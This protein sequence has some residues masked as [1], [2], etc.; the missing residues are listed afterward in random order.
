MR[1]AAAKR[2]LRTLGVGEVA[3]AT[4]AATIY[5]P[6]LLQV[7]N[8]LTYILWHGSIVL[9]R[10]YICQQVIDLPGEYK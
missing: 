2:Y 8:Q 5:E 3:V 7:S 6:S 9:V 10:Y 4:L 1:K